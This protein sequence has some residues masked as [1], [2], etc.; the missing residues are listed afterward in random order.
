M[1]NRERNNNLSPHQLLYEK[2]KTIDGREVNYNRYTGYFID[3]QSLTSNYVYGI[4]PSGILA[5]EMGLGK[6][7][8]VLSCILCNPKRPDDDFND[9]FYDI[10]T[11]FD[12]NIGLY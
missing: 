6:T 3:E 11:E 9:D 2:V 5:D 7:I 12:E 10:E 8:E 4:S 1:L